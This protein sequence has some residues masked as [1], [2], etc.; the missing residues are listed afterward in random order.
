[1]GGE[2]HGGNPLGIRKDHLGTHSFMTGT[3]FFDSA[4]TVGDANG[5]AKEE[6]KQPEWEA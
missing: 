3:V 6:S 1:M 5:T 2:R 4:G